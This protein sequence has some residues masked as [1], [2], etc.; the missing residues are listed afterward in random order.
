MRWLS[1]NGIERN[2]DE[3]RGV[4]GKEELVGMF[5][6]GAGAPIVPFGNASNLKDCLDIFTLNKPSPAGCN[7]RICWLSCHRTASRKSSVALVRLS[8]SLMRAQ[9]AC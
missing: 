3:R 2:L 1:I 8:F 4:D 5:A 7:Q 9:N 6:P